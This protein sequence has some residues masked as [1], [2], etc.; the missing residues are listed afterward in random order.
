MRRKSSQVPSIDRTC[1]KCHKPLRARDSRRYVDCVE[2]VCDTC[3]SWH[4]EM[5]TK[6]LAK[7]EGTIDLFQPTCYWCG[8]DV[9][10]VSGKCSACNLDNRR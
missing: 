3:H 1:P 5:R 6:L 9:D 4:Y 10:T 8:K 7:V 2:I